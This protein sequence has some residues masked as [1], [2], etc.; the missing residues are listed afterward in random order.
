MKTRIKQGG[1]RRSDNVVTQIGTR[2]VESGKYQ[3]VVFRKKIDPI[4][5]IETE[6]RCEEHRETEEEALAD[7]RKA[8]DEM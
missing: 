5:G 2:R 6:I 1:I 8:R 7:A 4:G 3:G